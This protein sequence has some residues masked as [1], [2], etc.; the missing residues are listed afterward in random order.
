MNDLAEILMVAKVSDTAPDGPHLA[1]GELRV[2]G[3]KVKYSVHLSRHGKCPR[4]W[5]YRLHSAEE[6]CKPC[7][8]VL[9]G[10]KLLP[11]IH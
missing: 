1:D 10:S 3:S 7:D 6:V 2:D 11:N 5:I 8:Q 9:N 4:C